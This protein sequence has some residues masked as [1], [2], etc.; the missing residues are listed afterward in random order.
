MQSGLYCLLNGDSTRNGLLTHLI[1]KALGDVNSSSIRKRLDDI[2]NVLPA[3]SPHVT[4]KR[5]R[6][7]ELFMKLSV[8]AVLVLEI[9]IVKFVASCLV[10]DSMLPNYYVHHF[11]FGVLYF[12]PSRNLFCFDIIRIHPAGLGM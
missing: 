5:S 11:F 9:I 6:V 7:D 12:C 3:L 1:V 10:S 2:I 4:F 8:A